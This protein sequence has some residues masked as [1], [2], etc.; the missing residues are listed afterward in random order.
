MTRGASFRQDLGGE[1]YEADRFYV[2]VTVIN[3]STRWLNVTHPLLLISHR[4]FTYPP[5][6]SPPYGTIKTTHRANTIRMGLAH[7]A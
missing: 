1:A 4:V 3:V 7:R 5:T 6:P 2:Q